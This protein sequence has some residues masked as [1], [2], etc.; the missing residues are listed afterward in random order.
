MIVMLIKRVKHMLYIGY[1]V[2]FIFLFFACVDNECFFFF[3]KIQ[4]FLVYNS[5]TI[6]TDFIVIIMI[7][8]AL[9]RSGA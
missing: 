7:S 4:I 5:V 3:F 9:A 2:L 1:L 8:S 6:G